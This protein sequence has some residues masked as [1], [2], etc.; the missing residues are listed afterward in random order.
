MRDDLD[1]TL[2]HTNGDNNRSHYMPQESRTKLAELK[3]IY[4]IIDEEIKDFINKNE[5]I[6][7][8]GNTDEVTKG[9][10]LK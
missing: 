9:G 2:Q 8:A 4:K 3:K 1:K 10:R 5:R 7:I 6:K